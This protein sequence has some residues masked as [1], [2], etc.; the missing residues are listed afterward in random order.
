VWEKSQQKNNDENFSISDIDDTLI[1]DLLKKDISDE[2]TGGY[3]LN[4]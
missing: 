2:G 1:Q 4:K 3:K